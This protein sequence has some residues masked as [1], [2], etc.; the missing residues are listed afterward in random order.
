M[1]RNR[2][3]EIEIPVEEST[4]GVSRP[5]PFQRALGSCPLLIRVIAGCSEAGVLS[6]GKS[7]NTVRQFSDTL[8][9]RS[10]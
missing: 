4:A 1:I 7:S 9:S 8:Q 6:T 2:E 5:A 3:N 10:T